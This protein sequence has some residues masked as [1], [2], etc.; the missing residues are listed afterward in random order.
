[1]KKKEEVQS[2]MA[3]FKEL[4]ETLITSGKAVEIDPFSIEAFSIG[5]IMGLAIGID[6]PSRSPQYSLREELPEDD[7]DV[8]NYRAAKKHIESLTQDGKTLSNLLSNSIE[9]SHTDF[10][11]C[12]KGIRAGFVIAGCTCGET[13]E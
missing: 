7:E 13:C 3:R 10:K 11:G 9:K 8:N 1:M 4:Q 12:I 2:S 5:G 6:I